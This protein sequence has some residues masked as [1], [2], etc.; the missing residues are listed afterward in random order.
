VSLRL[1]EEWLIRGGKETRDFMVSEASGDGVDAAF[2]VILLNTQ[3]AGLSLHEEGYMCLAS[4]I[5]EALLWMLPVV[6]GQA[7]RFDHVESP[8]CLLSE[9]WAIVGDCEH[10]GDVVLTAA[11]SATIAVV[12][13]L[14]GEKAAKFPEAA[15]TALVEHIEECL[16][17]MI[18]FSSAQKL[19]LEL[20]ADD[21]Q[22]TVMNAAAETA[23]LL[24]A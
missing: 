1:S 12:N 15:H 8:G 23:F 10:R 11:E 4:Q 6:K 22:Q 18:P 7:I 3:E 2:S 5:E 16:L 19:E 21:P 13:S 20:E 14:Y 17:T 24:A 9:E